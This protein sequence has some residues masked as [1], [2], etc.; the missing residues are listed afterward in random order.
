MS[1]N[2]TPRLG[3]RLRQARDR[4][5]VGRQAE[6]RRFTRALHDDQAD[7]RVL[8]VHGPGGVGKSALLRG[9]AAAAGRAGGGVVHVDGRTTPADPDSFGRAVRPATDGEAAVLLIDT[10]EHCGHLEDWLFEECLP[11]LP[12]DT[13]TVVAGRHAP[14][15][16]RLADPAWDGLV[17]V[18]PLGP[19]AAE[20]GERLLTA[21]GVPARLHREILDFTG[22][23]PLA[24]ALAAAV[25]RS[26]DTTR[27][28]TSD[29]VDWS[30]GQDVVSTLLRH[31]VGE[32]PSDAHRAALEVC[33]HA[34]VTT[35]SLLRAILGD[36][37]RDL[38][39]WLRGRPYV[40]TTDSGVFPHDVV[41]R[42]LEADLRW[43]D[44]DGF[45]ELHNA[46]RSH[47][48]E[49]VRTAAP[50]RFLQAVGELQ[51]LYRSDGFMADT[52]GWHPYGLV[53]D[54][55]YDATREAAVLDLVTL[56]EGP[57]SARIAAHWLARQPEGFHLQT[58]PPAGEPASCSAWLRIPPY[59]GQHE[60]PVVAAAWAHVGEHGPLRAG[61]H[62][63]VGRFQVGRDGY[64][65]PSPVMDLVLWRMLGEIVR[66]DRLAWSFIVMRDDGFWD[67]HLLHCDMR[68]VEPA[69]DIGGTR[70]R[71]FAHDWRPQPAA[72]W[73]AEKTD[74]MLGGTPGRVAP[75]GDTDA[76]VLDRTAFDHAVRAAL[77]S[78]RWPDELALNPLQRSRTA[79]G[80]DGTLY[81]LVLAAIHT[82]PSERGGEKGYRAAVAAFVEGASTQESAARRLGLPFSTYRR[83][84]ATAVERIVE[85]MWR[86]EVDGTPPSPARPSPGAGPRAGGQGAA[87]P[88]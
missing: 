33:A 35:E 44:P 70:Y 5:F 55:P 8:F 30:P 73:L 86:Q 79:L 7:V 28:A 13:V 43:R 69:V 20:D 62:I 87:N 61:E 2:G 29:A 71:L 57:E 15:P 19:L 78:L 36:Q 40:E 68:P 27:P 49:R 25:A 4:L 64:Q 67:R 80:H 37:G 41:R 82:L 81:D 14:D 16:V 34:H 24:L 53:R 45:E 9:Y 83:H 63:A 74:A 18:I 52:H 42:T 48:L 84:L 39:A 46:L 66:D 65:R 32:P 10:F 72:R 22:G 23:H 76:L 38:F 17:D 75:P 6:L 26:G 59:D 51:Y 56:R 12:A 47:L 85:I 3:D 21:R 88:S 31:L 1:A 11:R 60:D 50:H 58:M 77:R 54:L